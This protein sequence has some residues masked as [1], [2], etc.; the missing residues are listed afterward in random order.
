MDKKEAVIKIGKAAIE[1][2]KGVFALGLAIGAVNAATD[3]NRTT[4]RN[5]RRGRK[6]ILLPSKVGYFD[7]QILV[8]VDTI[9]HITTLQNMFE[10]KITLFMNSGEE[11][12]FSYTTIMAL[13][14]DLRKIMSARATGQ[15]YTFYEH[16]PFVYHF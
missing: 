4:V 14:T 16:K 9:R 13:R 6:E 1:I 11:I 8:D 15:S 3:R 7:E 10:R 12:V 2:A 5:V